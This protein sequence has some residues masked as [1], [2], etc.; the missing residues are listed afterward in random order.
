MIHSVGSFV[1]IYNHTHKLNAFRAYNLIIDYLPKQVWLFIKIHSIFVVISIITLCNRS[2]CRIPFHPIYSIAI[3]TKIGIGHW[4]EKY[5]I[6]PSEYFSCI[7]YFIHSILLM[8]FSDRYQWNEQSLD[9]MNT[10]AE[11]WNRYFHGTWNTE[12]K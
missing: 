10:Y 11:R 9:Q 2:N 4:P 3:F 7:S 1:L 6:A 12:N 5:L 8:E